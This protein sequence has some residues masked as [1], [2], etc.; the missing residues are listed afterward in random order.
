M[1]IPQGPKTFSMM[2]MLL[3]VRYPDVKLWEV[4]I[5]DPKTSPEHGQPVA[6]P[7]IVKVSFIS[8]ELD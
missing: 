3:S 7:I 5:K 2:S 1:I 8:D 4:I 6:N